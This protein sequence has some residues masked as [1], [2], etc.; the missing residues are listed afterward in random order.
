[1][2]N[3]S[4][5]TRV[6][7]SCPR[8]YRS[9]RISSGSENILSPSLFLAAATQDEI[10]ELRPSG[11]WTA[12]HANALEGLFDAVSPKLQQATNLKIDMTDVREL[13]TLG[14]WLLEKMSRMR[15]SPVTS[16]PLSAWR[17][18]MKAYRRC[19][20]GQPPQTR[21]PASPKPCPGATGRRRPFHVRRRAKR[22][23]FFCR[24]WVRW[25]RPASASCE[26][27]VHFG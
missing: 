24:C 26:G 7:E 6:S 14:A 8:R 13:D 18:V 5:Y 15:W 11:S 16:R 3:S 23:R 2:S 9:V 10:L 21:K 4:R 12:V 20:T 22:Y 1:M 27:R 25:V 17:A 19:S